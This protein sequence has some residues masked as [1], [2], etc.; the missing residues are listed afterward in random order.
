LVE[1]GWVA[2]A[3]L[4]LFELLLLVLLFV[5]LLVLLLSPAFEPVLVLPLLL[6]VPSLL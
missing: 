5:L 1:T 4:E 2:G 6:L 3:W